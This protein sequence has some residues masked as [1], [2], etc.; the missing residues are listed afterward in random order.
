M[1][2]S[3]DTYHCLPACLPSSSAPINQPAHSLPSPPHPILSHPPSPSRSASIPASY[4]LNHPVSAASFRIPA[5]TYI[6]LSR[7]H[8]SLL[9]VPRR[10][11]LSICMGGVS[12]RRTCAR[13]GMGGNGHGN[14]MQWEGCR[15]RGSL[16]SGMGCAVGRLAGR[17]D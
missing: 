7:W 12:W 14:G 10:F 9:P 6:S 5:L 15:T 13:D 3:I 8:I 11:P 17:Q 1:A 2:A 16:S 4:S